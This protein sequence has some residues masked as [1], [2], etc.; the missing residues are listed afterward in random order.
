MIN[1]TLYPT[2]GFANASPVEQNYLVQIERLTIA[3]S[4]QREI[5]ITPSNIEAT[6]STDP[7]V[8]RDKINEII[9]GLTALENSVI[10]MQNTLK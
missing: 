1:K 8:L 9:A 4:D 6:T 2:Q 3:L 5:V 10:A 7:A